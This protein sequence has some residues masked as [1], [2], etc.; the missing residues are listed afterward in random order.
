MASRAHKAVPSLAALLLGGSLGCS[1]SDPELCVRNFADLPL[2]DIVVSIEGR[3]FSYPSLP[4]GHVECR[5]VP[6]GEQ[7]NLSFRADNRVYALDSVIRV[8]TIVVRPDLSAG[9]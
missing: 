7:V 5:H 2:S 9:E 6:D 3:D 1:L 8:S 4:P